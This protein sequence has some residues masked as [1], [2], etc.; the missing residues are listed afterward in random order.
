MMMLMA[1]IM[2]IWRENALL[3]HR[4]ERNGGETEEDDVEFPTAAF[5]YECEL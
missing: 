2:T 1:M 4:S 3:D 5:F